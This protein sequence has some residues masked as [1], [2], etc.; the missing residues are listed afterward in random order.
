MVNIGIVFGL[1]LLVWIVLSVIVGRKGVEKVVTVGEINTQYK[2]LILYN[3]DPIYDLDNQITRAF[4]AGLSE[5]GWGSKIA[6]V[7]AFDRVKNESY[8]LYVFCANTYN[9]SPDRVLKDHIKNSNY[10]KGKNV[11][12]ITLGSGSTKRS[13]HILERLIID[14]KAILID[15]RTFWLMK[16]NDQLAKGRSNIKTAIN[17]ANSF[18]KEIAEQIKEN[19]R[20]LLKQ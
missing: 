10:L 5:N 8:D 6:T 7:A 17:L 14:K 3:P 4:A 9:W 15:S 16:P 2:A 19:N 12:A 1:T 13:K 18:G 20:E 11:I